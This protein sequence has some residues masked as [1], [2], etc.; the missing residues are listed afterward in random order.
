[1]LPLSGR[2]VMRAVW[3][4]AGLLCPSVLMAA[5]PELVVSPNETLEMQGLSVNVDQM[6]FHPIFRDEK[7]AGIQIMLHGERIATDGALRLNPTPEQWDPVPAF[8]KRERGPGPNQLTV[9]NSYSE[10]VAFTY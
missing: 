3:F 10:P 5:S 2:C 6:H 1:M 8:V 9:T 4:A 7:N